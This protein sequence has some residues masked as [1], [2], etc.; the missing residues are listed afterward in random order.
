MIQF[1]VV[2]DRPL[3]EVQALVQDLIIPEI[4]DIEGVTQVQLVGDVD[5]NFIVT[6]DL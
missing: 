5:R 1:G 4:E 6:A 3:I 2:S